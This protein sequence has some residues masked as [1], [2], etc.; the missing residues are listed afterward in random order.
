METIREQAKELAKRML[1]PYVERGDTQEQLAHG[2]LGRCG[3]G[4]DVHIGGYI[5]RKRLSPYQIA[6]ESVKGREVW[7]TTYFVGN[8]GGSVMNIQELFQKAKQDLL[9]KGQHAPILYVEYRDAEGKDALYYYYFAS[10]GAKT[11]LR[12][13]M[14]FFDLGAS[15]GLANKGVEF[16]RLTFISE[17]WVS[18]IP[19]RQTRTFRRPEDDPNKRE[20]L[21]AQMVEVMP[22][23]DGKPTLRQSFHRA[24]I[25]RPTTT[26]VEL[27]PEERQGEL[28]STLFPIYFLSGYASSHMS[29]AELQ[30]VFESVQR[31]QQK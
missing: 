5:A 27:A 1:R 20:Y 28:R 25:L 30:Q 9:D 19:Q 11:A 7:E 16:E 26:V 10:F 8:N 22:T 23:P 6:V 12:E 31:E 4:Y 24:Q 18:H 21:T 17:A 14:Q 29:E 3:P 13:K 2:G 15:F